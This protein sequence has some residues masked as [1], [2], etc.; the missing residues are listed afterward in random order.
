M[1]LE[2]GIEFGRAIERL[3]HHDRMIADLE[4][5][6]EDLHDQV[7]QIKAWFIRIGLV[8]TLLGAGLLTN[9]KAER[10]GDIAAALLRG[11]FKG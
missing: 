5:S 11:I 9:V 6:H 7:Q 10:I 1:D 4:D 3:S 8:A 2:T